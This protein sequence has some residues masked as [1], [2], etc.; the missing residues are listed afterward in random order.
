MGTARDLPAMLMGVYEETKIGCGSIGLLVDSTEKEQSSCCCDRGSLLLSNLE[1]I[2]GGATSRS[3]L[4]DAVMTS[5]LSIHKQLS[6]PPQ[7][8]S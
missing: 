1:E 2:G 3:T 5:T 8:K 7:I 4:T 6:S